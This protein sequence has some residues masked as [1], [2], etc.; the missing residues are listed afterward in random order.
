MKQFGYFEKLSLAARWFLKHDEAQAM[1]EDYRSILSEMSGPEEMHEHFGAPW[2]PVMELAKSKELRRHHISFIYLMFC[3]LYPPISSILLNFCKIDFIQDAVLF[4]ILL[5]GFLIWGFWEFLLAGRYSKSTSFLIGGS[6][7]L[8]FILCIFGAD[9]FFIEPHYISFIGALISL[10]SFG[11]DRIPERKLSKPLFYG[12]IFTF[13]CSSFIYGIVTYTFY[14][15]IYPVAYHEKFAFALSVAGLFF[16]TIAA[17][18]SI[19]LARMYDRRW[20][21]VYILA[22]GSILICSELVFLTYSNYFNPENGSI[23]AIFFNRDY[24]AYNLISSW[25]G[26]HNINGIDETFRL[27]SVFFG[28]SV[29]LAAIG[30]L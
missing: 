24:P 15:N 4:N 8:L 22:L 5:I 3:A 6:V 25:F 13:I 1:I 9:A 20:R 18:V 27:F 30:L 23:F 26:P 21:T 29:V 11:F 19:F 16:F 12:I 2:K 17:V 10:F 28:G 14:I 7:S